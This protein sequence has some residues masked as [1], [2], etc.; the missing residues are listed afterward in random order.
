MNEGIE[1]VPVKRICVNKKENM[2]ELN[3]QPKGN[4]VYVVQD[5][6]VPLYKKDSHNGNRKIYLVKNSSLL[7]KIIKI[8][9]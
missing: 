4:R 8:I 5:L 9:I 6:K 1:I 2:G 3:L 7:I